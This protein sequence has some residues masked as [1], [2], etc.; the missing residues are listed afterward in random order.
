MAYRLYACSVCDVNSAAAAAVCGLWSYTSV[1]C[2]CLCPPAGYRAI[3]YATPFSVGV[4]L[5]QLNSL[6]ELSQ[7]RPTV[8][9]CP[10]FDLVKVS[11]EAS[12]CVRFL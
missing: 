9:V 3:L 11:P 12:S 5:M 1:I 6:L 7:V 4:V 8:D 2:L 10:E